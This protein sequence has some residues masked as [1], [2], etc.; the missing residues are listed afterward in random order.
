MARVNRALELLALDQPIYYEHLDAPGRG[1]YEAG[2][3]AAGTWA[4]YL[5][6]DAE[7]APFDAAELR[8]FVRGLVEAGVT[9][10][11]HRTPAVIVSLPVDGRSEAV[12]RANAWMI[13]QALAAGVHGL[14]L[15]HAETPEAVQAFVEAARYPHQTLGVGEGLG[16]GRRGSGGQGYASTMWGL[17]VAE[18]M[19]RADAWPLNP[20]GELLLGLKIE[21]VRALANV[22]A[23]LAVPGISFAEWGPGDMGL[24]M[25]H[26]D[27]ARPAVPARHARGPGPR[28]GGLPG[29][30][31]RVPGPG[32]SGERDRAHRRGS[33]H[34]GRRAGPRGRRDRSPSH[35]ARHA[36]VAGRGSALERPAR[37]AGH[38]ASNTTIPE[39]RGIDWAPMGK[40]IYVEIAIQAPL[41]E[42]WRLTQSPDLHQ[43]WDLRFTRIAYLPRPDPGEPQRFRYETRIGFG[44]AVSGEGE[45]AG[46]R[47]LAD[48]RGAPRSDSGPPTRSR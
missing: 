3:A 2:R 7:H 35:E 14:L 30:R 27:P 43:R 34:R 16:V 10:S 1:G 28:A 44:L 15:C 46:E 45:T 48:G 20:D 47:D 8:E 29:G 4:D 40:P 31:H 11:G 33:P 17:T 19:A 18:Y 22:E 37:P 41:E 32:D 21:N 38:H 9:R 12:V 6:Y 24:S 36:L 26:P 5:S 13:R 23:S 39:A 42:L 25:G